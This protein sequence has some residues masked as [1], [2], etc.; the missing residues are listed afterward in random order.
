M[1]GMLLQSQY[2][3][4]WLIEAIGPATTDANLDAI[5]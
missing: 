1:I 3:M 2:A 4:H 5:G